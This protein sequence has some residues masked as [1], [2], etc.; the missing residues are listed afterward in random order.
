MM[1]LPCGYVCINAIIILLYK[2]EKPFIELPEI[3]QLRFQEIVSN[4]KSKI[5]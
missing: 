3:C 2:V 1:I 4:K 5:S